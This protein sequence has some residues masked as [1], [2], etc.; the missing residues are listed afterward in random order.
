MLL[1]D[2]KELISYL[3]QLWT[4]ADGD[5]VVLQYEDL[6]EQVISKNIIKASKVKKQIAFNIERAVDKRRMVWFDV[7]ECD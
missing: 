4:K 1:D 3:K 5:V 6:K 7:F 2:W